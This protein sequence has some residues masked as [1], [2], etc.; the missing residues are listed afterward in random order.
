MIY[1]I[2]SPSFKYKFILKIGYTM[3]E[4]GES[5]FEDYR[6]N[7]PEI[8]VLYKIPGGTQEDETNLHRYFRHL[9]CYRAEWYIDSQDIIDFFRTHTTK[10]SLEEI[11]IFGSKEELFLRKIKILR[12]FIASVEKITGK[13]DESIYDLCFNASESV[14]LEWICNYYSDLAPSIIQ[15]YEDTKSLLQNNER[16][17]E[18]I[19]YLNCPRNGS[20]SVRLKKLCETNEYTDEEKSLVAQQVSEKFDKFYN[21]IGPE[22]CKNLGYNVTDIK[23]EI[24]NKLIG[25]NNIK[26]KF[27]ETFNIGDKFSNPEAKKIINKIY[28]ELGLNLKAKAV[29]LEKYFNVKH[30]KIK[31]DTGEWVNGIII[32]SIKK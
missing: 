16:L 8:E 2:K 26:K 27:L 3:D 21:I 4:R 24:K 28:Q 22:R 30:A 17:K 9:K 6:S 7:N 18:F 15:D 11:N 1:L 19:E 25:N 23:K 31:L 29:D 20:L 5:R 10:E 12:P 14:G 13:L 32:N